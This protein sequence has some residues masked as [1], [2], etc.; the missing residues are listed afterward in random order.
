MVRQTT[1]TKGGPDKPGRKDPSLAEIFDMFPDEQAAME[2]LE[3]NVWS[4]GRVC[5]RCANKYTCTSKHPNMPYYCSECKKRFSVRINTVMESSNIRYR[6][7]AVTTYLMA[8]RPKGI[9]SVQLAKDLGISQS[10]AWFLLHRLRESWRSLAGPDLAMAGPVEVDEVYLGGRE[11]NKHADK[12]GRTK[13]TAV[14]G[15]KDRET[16]AIRVVPVPETTGARLVEFVGLNITKGARVFTDE[17]RAY[18]DLENH[19]TVN[20]GDGE[21]VRGEVHI[22]GMES[23]WA[24]VRRGYNGTFHHIDPKHL[25]RYVNEFSGRLSDKA[26]GVIERM[27]E[28]VRNLVGKRLTY[29]QLVA[30]N[31]LCGRL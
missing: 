18:N 31:A 2:W 26:V 28:I 19:H 6:D 9:S 21:Y 17:N 20:H 7:W 14:V 16:G 25:H 15:I 13:K 3:R 29:R 24:P 27:G 8:T 12:K 11:K 30:G 5:P 22:N 10:A 23:F 1:K 4:D